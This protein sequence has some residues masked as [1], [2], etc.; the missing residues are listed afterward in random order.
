MKKKQQK[1]KKETYGW[2]WLFIVAFLLI[3]FWYSYL[4]VS[5][6]S[7]PISGTYSNDQILLVGGEMENITFGNTPPGMM[8]CLMH[9]VK[10][11]FDFSVKV[12]FY[13]RGKIADYITIEPHRL[14]L[15]PGEE[16]D[17][18]ICFKPSTATEF[19]DYEGKLIVLTRR[20]I[21]GI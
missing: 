10:N 7:K 12:Y 18:Q 19:G 11:N 15:E 9:K 16:K 4:I 21:F 6:Y 3:Y 14:Y 20:Q 13:S 5:F 1:E 2:I 8:Q 17:A